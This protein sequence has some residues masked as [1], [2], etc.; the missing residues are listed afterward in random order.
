VTPKPAWI[1]HGIRKETREENV[2]GAL[3][4]IRALLP[5]SLL[6]LFGLHLEAMKKERCIGHLRADFHMLKGDVRSCAFER[7][8]SWQRREPVENQKPES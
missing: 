1:A 3:A 5:P 4:T 8:T 2:D 7:R 6:V